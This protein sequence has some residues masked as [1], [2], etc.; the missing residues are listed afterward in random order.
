MLKIERIFGT[1]PKQGTP[2]PSAECH[3]E[4]DDSPLLDLDGHHKYQMV[5]GMLQWLMNIGRPI[6]VRLLQ[7]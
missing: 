5:L 6:S 7:A 3:P 2:L 4:M 1:H